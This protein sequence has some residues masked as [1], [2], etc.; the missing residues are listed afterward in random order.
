MRI[1][2]LELVGYKRLM[3]SNIHRFIYTPESHYQ[4]IL[5]TNGSGKSSVLNELSPL[6]AKSNDFVKDGYKKITLEHRGSMYI[7]TSTF[8]SSNKHSFLRDGNEC[9]EG[10]T[11]KVQEKLV[12]ETFGLTQELHELLIGQTL[13]TDLAP[14][15]RREWC[16]RLSSADYRFALALYQKLKIAARDSQGALKHVKKRLLDETQRLTEATSDKTVEARVAKLHE[17]ITALLYARIPNAPTYDTVRNTLET[18]LERTVTLSETIIRNKCK[19]ASQNTWSSAQTLRDAEGA[20]K[21]Q[22]EDTQRKLTHYTDEFVELDSFLKGLNVEGPEGDLTMAFLDA[23]QQLDLASQPTVQ[24]HHFHDPVAMLSDTVEVLDQLVALFKQLPDNQ[25]R[26]YSRDSVQ[27]ANAL[28]TTLRNELDQAKLKA[29]QAESRITL[30][31]SAKELECPNCHYVWKD[32]YSDDELKRLLHLLEE[33]AGIETS[34]QAKVKKLEAF[35][36]EAE[37]YAGLYRQFRGLVASYPRLKPLWDYILQ[38]GLLVN[39]PQSRLEVFYLWQRDLEKAS[40][41]AQA[42][43]QYT[44]LTEL[45]EKQQ[46]AEGAHFNLRL[47]KLHNAIET[48]TSELETLRVR[49]RKTKAY[50]DTLSS[51]ERATEELNTLVGELD[52]LVLQAFDALSNDVVD[53]DVTIKQ[54][55]L[56]LEQRKLNERVALEGVVEDLNRSVASLDGEFE[57]RQLLVKAM[58]PEGGLIADQLKNSIGCLIAQVNSI[59]ASI[60]TYDLTVAPCG[61]ESGDLDYKFPLEVGGATNRVPDIK[62]GSKAQRE[63]VNFAFQLTAMLYLELDDYPLYLDELG[64]SFDEQHRQNLIAFIKQLMDTKR[65][66]MLLMVSH[67]ADNWAA[68]PGAEYLVLDGTNIAVPTGH[69][70]HVSLQ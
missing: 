56:G 39:S 43:A 52:Q 61:L 44:K 29:A 34:R 2:G 40:K 47:N 67:Y 42:Q 6:P 57:A 63:I 54:T 18:A 4:L 13:F 68:F 46:H 48:A 60:W 31:K 21:G 64:A 33:C 35:Q 32:G 59:I 1:L 51:L 30:L 45:M 50:A 20:L 49:Y 22:L 16:T 9:N 27:Q 41:K 17:E 70:Q 19:L 65:H 36:E 53:R 3:L 23:E 37:T 10:G 14:L 28:L 69:N 26:R 58:S 55:Q 66:S 11:G 62:F 12:E 25:D 7:L 38:E 5:G 8:K 24:F 15:K